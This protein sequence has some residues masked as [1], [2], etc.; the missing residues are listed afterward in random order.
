MS[1][2]P[3]ETQCEPFTHEFS[4]PERFDDYLYYLAQQALS[5]EHAVLEVTHT[6]GPSGFSGV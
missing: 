4:S 1:A 5:A 2:L 6:R 3:E